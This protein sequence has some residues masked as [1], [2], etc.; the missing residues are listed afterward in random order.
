MVEN[1]IRGGKCSCP[2]QYPKANN[3]HMKDYDKNKELSYLQYLDVNNLYNVA[4]SHKF[5]LDCFEWKEDT[6]QFNED[7][8]KNY[9][10]EC[11]KG[12]FLEVDL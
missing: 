2:Y 4:K 3:K 7:F 5:P 9:N 12:Y 8:I 10:I 11:N 6:S 1:R